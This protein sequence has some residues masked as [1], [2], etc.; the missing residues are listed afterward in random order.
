MDRVTRLKYLEKK[1]G[2]K[3]AFIT[4]PDPCD[5]HKDVRNRALPVGSRVVYMNHGCGVWTGTIRNYN[6]VA[7]S[8]YIM[9]DDTTVDGIR[10]TDTYTACWRVVQHDQAKHM[11]FLLD[12]EEKP[13]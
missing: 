2:S 3:A 5:L 8:I 9:P 10:I 4:D 7:D 13:L 6:F 11:L 12:K 1:Y